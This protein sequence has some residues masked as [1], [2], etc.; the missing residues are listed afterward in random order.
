MGYT[1]NRLRVLATSG[2]DF[3]ITPREMANIADQLDEKD[4]ELERLQN[5]SADLTAL[6]ERMRWV[7]VSERLP[8]EGVPVWVFNGAAFTGRRSATVWRENL[9]GLKLYGVT[10][11]RPIDVPEAP[12]I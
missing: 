5:V 2:K 12:N 1:S 4:V 7:P 8:D 6:R 10:H 3:K 11:W 9:H